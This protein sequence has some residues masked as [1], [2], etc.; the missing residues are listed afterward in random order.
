MLNFV[1]LSRRQ[2]LPSLCGI[3]HSAT[4]PSQKPCISVEY[5]TN[6]LPPPSGRQNEKLMQHTIGLENFQYFRHFSKTFK[7]SLNISVRLINLENLGK[8]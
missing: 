1:Q 6:T 5:R 3:P 7:K 4:A 8:F 2:N